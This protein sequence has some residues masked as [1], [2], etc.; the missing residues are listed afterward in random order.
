MHAISFCCFFLI[1]IIIILFFFLIVFTHTPATCYF[2]SHPAFIDV[3]FSD[4]AN[5]FFKNLFLQY[6]L[7]NGFGC[8]MLSGV[9]VLLSLTVFQQIVSDTMPITSLQI[10]LLGKQYL[11]IKQSQAQPFGPEKKREN[12]NSTEFFFKAGNKGF[13]PDC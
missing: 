12:K 4:D 1:S 6:S 13:S 5:L 8:C 11:Y 2:L 7:F 10:P 3:I 9:T